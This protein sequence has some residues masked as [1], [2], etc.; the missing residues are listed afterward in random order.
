ML[1]GMSDAAA[2]P[3][4][5][6]AEQEI[7]IRELG[8]AGKVI[9]QLTVAGEVGRVTSGGRLVGWLVPATRMARDIADPG[10]RVNALSTLVAAYAAAGEHDRAERMAREITDPSLRASALSALVAAC[11]AAGER[12]RAERIAI[13]AERIAR[14]ITDPGQRASALSTLVAAS[15]AAGGNDRAG[16]AEQRIEE[17]T[18]RGLLRPPERAGGL[19]GWR[20]LPRRTDVPPLSETLEQMRSDERT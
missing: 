13:D 4:Q 18:A 19:A 10:Q 1:T 8:N 12:D 16:S 15:A 14:E 3:A 7:A 6:A 5:R 17:L 11:A 9:A 2:V 20:P